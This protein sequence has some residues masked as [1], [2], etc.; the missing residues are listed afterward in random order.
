MPA[1]TAPLLGVTCVRLNSMG[2]VYLNNTADNSIKRIDPVSGAISTVAGNGTK[3]FSGDGGPAFSAALSNPLAFV[4]D[5]QGNILICDTYNNRVR[6]IDAQT[7]IIHTIAGDGSI[8]YKDGSP[9]TQSGIASPSSIDIDSLG[10]IYI[11]TSEY[12]SHDRSGYDY[13]LKID[14]ATGTI[15]KLA[16]NGTY[17]YTGTGSNALQTGFSVAGLRVSTGGDIYFADPLHNSVLKLDIATGKI[18]TVAGSGALNIFGYKGDGG[19]AFEALLNAPVDLCFDADSNLLIVDQG[20][21]VIRKINMQSGDIATVAGN[22]SPGYSG[23]G[24]M[25]TCAELHMLNGFTRTSGITAGKSHGFFFCDQGNQCIR[26][27]NDVTVVSQDPVFSISTD[28]TNICPGQTILLK[29][30]ISNNIR[31]SANQITC[32][33]YLNGSL[34]NG[35]SLT[36][37]SND[38]KNN[39]TVYCLLRTVNNVCK[40]VSI[41]SNALVFSTKPSL[42]F[43]VNITPGDTMVCPSQNIAFK[44]SPAVNNQAFQYLW[45]VNGNLTNNHD[46][47]FTARQPV[48][49]DKVQ[50][51]VSF[52]SA[53]CAVP[54]K[55]GSA[56][57][58]V[59]VKTAPDITLTPADTTIMPG[60]QVQLTATVISGNSPSYY[61][62]PAEGL[63]N[64]SILNPIASPKKTIQYYFIAVS[65]DQCRSEKSV[66]VKVSL[67]LMMPSAFTPNNDGKN[68]IFRIPAGIP[69]ELNEFS[70]YHRWGKK[71]F[72]TKNIAEGWNGNYKNGTPAE[73]G[74]YIFIINGT[75]QNKPFTLNGTVVLLR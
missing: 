70:V 12:V 4:I 14:A 69:L 20:S 62:L 55:I 17:T 47:S 23:D 53:D 68:D 61:W 24:G 9:T 11:G 58:T 3:G 32:Q 43:A 73:Q 48:N 18:I 34:L 10:N 22:G 5:R 75:I 59:S 52:T 16:G 7:N 45:K 41:K 44:I 8:T 64:V 13:I 60:A 50:G 39:D 26:K 57:T 74:T 71:I 42:S 66:I 25:A 46:S 37:Q 27:V 67:P 36:Y 40:T 38:L 19:P 29:G 54:V 33:W 49:G 1:T 30:S 15:K 2:V 6:K 63:S 35:D 31:L 65:Q 51:F 72:S 28:S 21:N 56:I